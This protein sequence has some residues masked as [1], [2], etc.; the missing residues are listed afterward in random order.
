MNSRVTPRDP[1]AYAVLQRNDKCCRTDTDKKRTS[2]LS[3]LH[4]GSR[5][6]STDE[7]N[8]QTANFLPHAPHRRR[9][10]IWWYVSS[11]IRL[12]VSSCIRDKTDCLQPVRFFIYDTYDKQHSHIVYPPRQ[13]LARKTLKSIE[14]IPIF[15]RSAKNL[16][17]SRKPQGKVG[18]RRSRPLQVANQFSERSNWKGS[19]RHLTELSAT[20]AQKLKT[21]VFHRRRNAG[22]IRFF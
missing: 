20:F 12:V 15:D 2:W 9:R 4:W 10:G 19:D 11:S 13:R 1:L 6:G 21:E 18:V 16:S 5:S 22:W 3:G 8:W 14:L 17:P 7:G